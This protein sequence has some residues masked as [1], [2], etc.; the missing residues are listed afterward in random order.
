MLPEHLDAVVQALAEPCMLI[1]RTG[2][3]FAWNRAARE[4]FP[5]CRDNLLSIVA[6]PQALGQYLTFCARSRSPLPGSLR[7]LRVDGQAEPPSFGCRAGLLLQAGEG[8]PAMVLIRFS[9]KDEQDPF[10]RLN[11]TIAQLTE[12]VRRRRDAEESL[13]AL[14]EEMARR[15]EQRFGLLVES[16]KD[17]AIFMLDP[18]GNVASWNEGA[19]RI[20]GYAAEE[21]IGQHFS[22][23]YPPQPGVL[24]MCRRELAIAAEHGRFE[25]ES[26]RVRKD[27]SRFL[28]NV[29]ITALRDSSGT[30][31]GFAKVT[32]D[33]TER[34]QHEH[35][36]VERARAEAARRVAEENE[37]RMR[38]M[39]EE[40]RQARDQ[41]EATTRV[42]DEFLA[43]L[44]HE[45]RTPLNAILG[46]G[47]LLQGG[48]VPEEQ[49][50]HAVDTIV[51]NAL[52]QNRLIDDLLDVSRII[53]GKFRLDVE[54]IDINAVSAAAVDVVRPA[55]EAKGVRLQVI[56]DPDGGHVMGDASRLQQV[57]WNLLS[58]AVKFTPKG[59]RV[60]VTLRRRDSNVEITVTD[61]G[62]GITPGFLPRVFDRFAQQSHD[63]LEVSARRTG[64]LGLGLALVKHIVELHGGTVV[65][66]SEGP[67]KGASFVVR[68]PIVPV[69][70]AAAPP[71]ASRGQAD[72]EIDGQCPPEVEGLRV[73]VIDDE[74]DSRDVTKATLE[75]CR[76]IVTT[77]ASASEAFEL[78]RG[79]PRPDVIVS[80]IG[81]PDEDGYAF[82]R[83]LRALPRE[84]GGRIPA[85]ALTAF[86]RA[87]DRRR[88]L[89]AGFQNHAAKPI[90]P[91]ELLVVVANLAGRF[92]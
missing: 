91:Q 4:A 43:T 16:V 3:I 25:D 15:S 30:L 59:G 21:I 42:K 48:A 81:M 34:K 32:R 54:E 19:Q 23:F 50:E 13:R 70:T 20:K 86:A 5:G 57:M 80:D 2:Q 67:G 74:S 14:H 35:D 78:L 28:A 55:A 39:A 53:T 49:G 56:F 87:D 8:S 1:S 46:W 77:A 11:Q 36:R 41:A 92:L 63:E 82:I 83:R 61:T 47:R 24:E 68:L 84:E 44:S 72:L 66:Q 29:V 65:A 10:L 51:R 6:D 85:V 52:A 73:L 79:S 45:L 76:I 69:R 37:A 12:E 62:A 38:E 9:P 26:P 58:N 27:G 40:L 31:V 71:P 33:L 18:E 17:Y 90:E 7:L 75:R 64:G 22:R 89:T 88:A 60:H